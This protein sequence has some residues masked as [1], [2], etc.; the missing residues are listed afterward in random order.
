MKHSGTASV[1][2]TPD[3]NGWRVRLP[4]GASLSYS[5]MAE[6]AATLPAAGSLHLAL[7]C[8]AALIERMKLP[9]TDREELAGML[10]LQLEKTLPFPIEDVSNGF[11]V[12]EQSEAESTIVSV[13]TN[14]DQLDRLCEPLRA[15]GRLPEKVT[16]YALHV[17]AA[18][19]P[20]AT[21]LA[22]WAEDRQLAL[23]ICERGKLAY[24]QT[25][26]G[27]DAA[28]L[29]GELPAFMLSAEMEG[30]PTEFASIR[31]EQGVGGLRDHL[32]EYFGKTVEFIS[33]DA[34]L[35]EPAMNLVPAA[36]V[37]ETKRVER[38]GA[39]KQRLQLAA[40]VYLLLV[41]GACIYLVLQ[42]QR[43][44]ALDAQ[45]AQLQPQI[46][47]ASKQ[48]ARWQALAP[49]IDPSRYAVE[50]VHLLFSNR[51]SNDVK[52]TDLDLG[53]AHFKVEGEVPNLDLAVNFIEKLRKEP[54]L[55]AF[56]IDAPPPNLLPNDAAHFVVYGKR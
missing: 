38:S 23:A 35:P 21:V 40:A 34:P 25:V 46:D 48:Q 15:R 53:L 1:L 51:P 43:V 55:S 33:Y 27:V 7:P 56:K 10:Q 8:Q 2:L 16:V 45:I 26:S 44:R 28:T 50:I 32:A 49:A 19:P 47:E 13:S 36:W 20:D 30:V 5:T 54:S 17:A 14:S 42:K 11:D 31:L 6:V 37:A 3:A 29:V 52:F 39:M 24:A 4:G 41:A 9:A 18:C 12:I 22:V